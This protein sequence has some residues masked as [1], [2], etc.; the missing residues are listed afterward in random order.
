MFEEFKTQLQSEKFGADIRII[1]VG[2]AGNSAVEKMLEDKIQGVEFIIANTDNQ[3]LAASKIQKK[4][5]LGK[6]ITKGLGAG[7]HPEV[8]RKAAEESIDEINALVNGAD[9][10]FVAAGLGGG[11]GTGAAPV[12]A[13]A[14]KEA[15]AIVVAIV[16]TPFSFE[17]PRRIKNAIEGQSEIA[18]V[19]D[20]IIV[21]SNDRLSDELGQ[22]SL[23]ESFKYSDA[24]LKQAVRTIADLIQEHST[25]NLDFADVRTVLEG[26]GAALIGVGRSKGENA[27]IEA[28]VNAI[29]SPILESSINGA[30]NAIINI[31]GTEENLTIEKAREAVKTVKEAADTELDIMFGITTDDAFGDEIVVSVIATGLPNT[32]SDIEAHSNRTMSNIADETDIDK[33]KDPAG[34]REFNVNEYTSETTSDNNIFEG[35]SLL[36]DD[37]EEDRTIEDLLG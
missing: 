37:D 14:A 16:T 20:S 13:K 5:A 35:F 25:I 3:V 29:Q 2:G 8:G 6:K 30:K 24:V 15:G 19:V 26:Q 7:S 10:V 23:S 22:I 12:I 11:T 17:G 36:D 27:A 31:A 1:G 34:T 18:K 32:R 21:V 9:L 33:Y 4:I 28:A